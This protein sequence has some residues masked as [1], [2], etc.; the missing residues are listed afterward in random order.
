[1]QTVENFWN[2]LAHGACYK[3][4]C[5]LLILKDRAVEKH[6]KHGAI[7]TDCA[8]DHTVQVCIPFNWCDR[9]NWIIKTAKQDSVHIKWVKQAAECISIPV[10]ISC[11]V[12]TRL[13][14]MWNI[15]MAPWPKWP[16]NHFLWIDCFANPFCNPVLSNLLQSTT[17]WTKSKILL[18]VGTGWCRFATVSVQVCVLL[19][20][21]KKLSN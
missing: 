15:P 13:L 20:K 16:Q 21:P 4:L 5:W 7:V 11:T 14:K 17:E 18:L 19:R 2:G 9:W 3:L 8:D 6:L 1:M 10:W 12:E